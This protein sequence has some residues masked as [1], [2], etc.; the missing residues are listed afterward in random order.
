MLRRE[1][2]LILFRKEHILVDGEHI[3]IL[4][5]VCFKAERY[6]HGEF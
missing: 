5:K 4:V 3:F 2:L 1:L 6:L